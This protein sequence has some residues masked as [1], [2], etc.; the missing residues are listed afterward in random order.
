MQDIRG[1]RLLLLGSTVWK[2]LIKSF[3]DYYGVRLYFAGLYPAPLDDMVEEYYRIDTTNPEVM[4]PFVKGHKF[5]GVYIPPSGKPGRR[6]K[7]QYNN[8]RCA[9]SN[10]DGRS[11]SAL[12][13]L[14]P[15]GSLCS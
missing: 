5:D 9:K 11:K 4:I 1:K 3:A 8:N 7:T 12:V 10:R 15:L 2:D 14:H 13:V 6:G